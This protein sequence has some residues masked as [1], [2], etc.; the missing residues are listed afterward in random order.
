MTEPL[1]AMVSYQWDD[2]GAAELLHVELAMRGL[3]V[4]HDRC[5]FPSGSRIGTCQ[6]L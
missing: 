1:T 5:T 6:R 4:L 2:S 3:T